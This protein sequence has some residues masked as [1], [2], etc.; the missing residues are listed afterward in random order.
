[1]KLAIYAL[2][3]WNLL[4][5]ALYGWDKRCARRGRRRVPEKRLLGVAFVGGAL[6][7]WLGARVLRHKTAKP[8]FYWPLR[9]AVLVNLCFYGAIAY[10]WFTRG[11]S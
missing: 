8:S 2:L 3:G 11:A 5:F 6:G 1:M 10:V 7:A 9:V 4:T